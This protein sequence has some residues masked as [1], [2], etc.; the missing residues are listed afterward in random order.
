MLK[1]LASFLFYQP[2]KISPAVMNLILKL[3]ILKEG[4]DSHKLS[5]KNKCPKAHTVCH[6][7]WYMINS[8]APHKHQKA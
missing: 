6:A 3:K 2:P 4:R 1:L 7:L 5:Q 8:Q